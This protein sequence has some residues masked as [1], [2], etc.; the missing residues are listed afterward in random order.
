MKKITKGLLALALLLVTLVSFSSRVDAS[1]ISKLSFDIVLD[2]NSNAKITQTWEG[3]FNEGTEVYQAYENM[4][5][6]KITDYSVKDET[7]TNYVS[8]D[9]SWNVDS[10]REYKKNKC[11]IVDKSDGYELCFGIGDYGVHTYTMTYTITNFVV[12]YKDG[13]QGINWQLISRNLSP[14]PNEFSIKIT[15]PS[16]PFYDSN[17]DIYGFGYDGQCVFDDN[18][19][20]YLSN[21][22]MDSN[23]IG[24]VN[25][26]N[27]FAKFTEKNYTTSKTSS[28]TYKEALKD[29]KEGSDYD[30]DDSIDTILPFLIIGIVFIAI[31]I[32][33]VSI[34]VGT[35]KSK[36]IGGFISTDDRFLDNSMLNSVKLESGYFRDIPCNKDLFYLYYLIKKIGLE[37]EEDLKSSLL[38][39]VLLGWIRD[40]N[41]DFTRE[42]GTG[43]FKKDKCEIDFSKPFNAHN[44]LEEELRIMFMKACGSNKVL[45]DKEFKKWCKNNY[46]DVDSWFDKIESAVEGNLIKRGELTTS[47][48]NKKILFFSY[49]SP[50][51]YYGNNVREEIKHVYGFNN[52]IDE[53]TLLDEKDVKEVHLWED[54]LIFATVFGKADKVKDEIGKLYPEFNNQSNIDYVYTP[55]FTSMYCMA[56]IRSAS[57]AYAA[58]HS[59]SSSGGGGFSS[60]GGGGGGFSG[61]GGGGIR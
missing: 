50:V 10:T 3:T 45:E 39:A 28:M 54:Y 42:E 7:G 31:I 43:F 48:V 46:E 16:H 38:S 37:N 35:S 8:L 9:H 11:G 57:Q 26:A 47:M 36:Q 20:I 60:F 17:T 23:S 5:D 25:Y 4:G 22:S 2:D 61:G 56:G 55:Y 14:M 33:A 29:A 1:S 15:N 19:G 40:G 32:F 12:E 44:K 27:I 59:S 6:S 52:F 58:A 30:D 13:V 53:F 18:G 21:I 24:T 41:L 34:K 51:T 49:Q